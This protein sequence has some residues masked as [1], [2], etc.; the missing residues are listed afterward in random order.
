MT[1]L[2]RAARA[3]LGKTSAPVGSSLQW[4]ARVCPRRRVLLTRTLD[5]CQGEVSV[6]SSKLA[7]TGIVVAAVLRRVTSP[8]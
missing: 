2:S 1:S 5:A 6:T 3:R 4:A 7:V 8:G